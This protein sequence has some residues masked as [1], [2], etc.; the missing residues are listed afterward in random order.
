[1][2][3]TTLTKKLI[4]SVFITILFVSSKG[5][6]EDAV[7]TNTPDVTSSSEV[8]DTPSVEVNSAPIDVQTNVASVG[9]ENT[10]QLC[11]DGI[12]NN[13]NF[14]VDASDPSC[15]QFYQVPGFPAN[16]GLVVLPSGTE[17]TYA[18]CHDGIDN[19]GNFLVDGSD[20]SCWPFYSPTQTYRF[21]L[22]VEIRNPFGGTLTD[23]SNLDLKLSAGQPGLLLNGTGTPLFDE[24]ASSS[25]WIVDN[26]FTFHPDHSGGGFVFDTKN[27]EVITNLGY[28]SSTEG[29]CSSDG[30]FNEPLPGL[31]LSSTNAINPVYEC[32]FVFTQLQPQP[33]GGSLS[34]VP[35]FQNDEGGT[36]TASNFMFT[37]YSTSSP[38]STSAVTV[39]G[40]DLAST[41]FP[42][43]GDYHVVVT[44][45]TP[46]P[47]PYNIYFNN[48]DCVGNLTSGTKTCGITFNDEHQP[49]YKT[50]TV[51]VHVDVL[52]A[53]GPATD[54]TPLN[55]S[56]NATGS[57]VYFQGT[58]SVIYA[59]SAPE[60]TF[61]NK[62]FTF[63][64]DGV[65]GD[66]F[67][68]NAINPEIIT[69]Q[70]YTYTNTAPNSNCDSSNLAAATGE[71]NHLY[72]HLQFTKN[73]PDGGGNPT[74]AK[75]HIHKV[76]APNANFDQPFEFTLVQAF[77]LAQAQVEDAAPSFIA[78]TTANAAGDEGHGD[79]LL[80]VAPGS[81]DLTENAV[82]LWRLEGSSCQYEGNSEGIVI[83]N[84]EQLNLDAGDEVFCTFT[85]RADEGNVQVVKVVQD[86]NGATTS[87]NSVFDVS[88]EEN[89][90]PSFIEG[91]GP[92]F[93][94][95]F[96]QAS[97]GVFTNVTPGVYTVTEGATSTYDL[98]S[99]S[100][101]T[102]EETRGVQI[103]VVA[104]TTTVVTIVNKQHAVPVIVTPPSGG[105]GSSSGGGGGSFSGSSNRNGVSG[106]STGG[107]VLGAFT[108]NDGT[109]ALSCPPFIL[110]YLKIG[111]NN[112]KTEVKKLQEFLNWH[113]TAKLPVTGFFGPAT[114]KAVENYQ[115]KYS[116]QI[117]KPWVDAGL[118]QTS[119]PTGYVYKTT[120]WHINSQICIGVSTSTDPFPFPILN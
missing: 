21:D 77:P 73:A 28:A 70:G 12:D 38:T 114:K 11:H 62:E 53:F 39:E 26:Y 36:S 37:V 61:E 72:C 101:D 80:E 76:T 41:T 106:G 27:P 59:T 69:N 17:D 102:D 109:P 40:A 98:V 60:M 10:F 3:G 5:F 115:K 34:I 1:M 86:A 84:G 75:I 83:H 89:N 93:T 95:P 47:G 54:R 63:R 66:S 94:L 55:V 44:P 23:F 90:V 49:P 20:P 110:D 111:K 79:A 105:G 8:I 43:N 99:I 25:N 32:T 120:R 64:T 56:V 96:S 65:S 14:L 108:S 91:P 87:D 74:T 118:M 78:T 15:Y 85:N 57:G 103:N 4:L 31:L 24:F 97:S 7:V 30:L 16:P 81:Y 45:G 100:P 82:P 48:E 104:G 112:S 116:T 18:L 50:Y 107:S 22:N 42:I 119:T 29:T 58:G 51:S 67:A 88:L 19:N 35:T 117:L 13:A 9:T 113:D 52:N 71:D 33:T 92:T 2:K 46:T 68:I 6:A